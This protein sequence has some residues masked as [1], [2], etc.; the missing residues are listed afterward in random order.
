MREITSSQQ[1]TVNQ[2]GF[3]ELS[4]I[5]KRYSPQPSEIR[6]I[7]K[8][9]GWDPCFSTDKRY[10]CAEQCEWRKDCLKLRAVWLR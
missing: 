10:N 6:M 8:Q 7:Q 9:R 2:A 4:G 3:D 5:Y 1:K